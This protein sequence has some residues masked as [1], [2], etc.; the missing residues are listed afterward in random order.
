[1][2]PVSVATLVNT[3]VGLAYKLVKI[4]NDLYSGAQRFK[5]AETS[6]RALANQCSCVATSIFVLQ[7]WVQSQ[8]AGLAIHERVLKQLNESLVITESIASDLSEKLADAA[9]DAKDEKNAFGFW[10]KAKV[11]WNHS[12]MG[13]YEH[14][15][16]GQAGCMTLLLS[17]MQMYD[18]PKRF[19]P[20]ES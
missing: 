18:P 1:M 12:I 17:S 4:S 7:Q 8:A 13:E 6:L 2:D 19:T 15:L 10:R 5:K 3:C 16:L 9:N 14:R 20:N 11:V